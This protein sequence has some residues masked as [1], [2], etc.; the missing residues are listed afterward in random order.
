MKIA[1]CLL[2]LTAAVSSFAQEKDHDKK[3]EEHR[4]IGHRM[5]Q[6]LPYM[7]RLLGGSFQSFDG[8]NARVANVP[9]YKQL[10]N[11][12]PTIGLGWLN[13][14]KNVVTNASLVL[15]S[16]MSGHRNEKSSTVRYIGVNADIGYDVVKSDLIMLYPMVGLGLQKYQA[17]FYRD[18][19][20]VNFNDVLASPA[21]ENSISSVRFKNSYTVYRF[22]LGFSV[23]TPKYPAAIGI[24][25]G[26]TGSFKK[27][28][29]HTNEDQALGNA[30]E[31]RI[32]QFYVSL[33]LLSKPW[34]MMRKM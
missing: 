2:F 1:T 26:Y 27:N 8:L 23:K 29:W 28:Q 15:G 21:I 30:P 33:L 32:S 20:S 24:Q 19:T 3:P 4:M 12:S 5:M 22:G 7:T 6:K 10:N 34:M 18:N 25:A 9:Q 31:D 13:D 14:Y 17:L 11:F 16:T